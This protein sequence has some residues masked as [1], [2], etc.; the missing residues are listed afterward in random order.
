MSD[1]VLSP[2][3]LVQRPLGRRFFALLHAL[4]GACRLRKRNEIRSLRTLMDDVPD[5][6][7]RMDADGTIRL[8]SASAMDLLGV[9]A[10]ACVGKRLADFV[11]A[12]R[13]AALQRA[14]EE[15]LAAMQTVVCLQLRRADG[16]WAWAETR[17]RSVPAA[18]RFPAGFVASCRD[19]SLQKDVEQSLI[20]ARDQALAANTAKSRFL[21]GMSHELRTPLNA[22]LGF[23]EVM[24]REM[25]GPHGVAKYREY[26]QLIHESG[27]H[28][29]ELINGVLDIS[30]I[31]AGKLEIREEA[32]ALD[33]AV[34]ASVRFVKMV[35]ERE[36][37]TVASVI[38]PAAQTIYADKRAV[39]QILINLL[40]NAVKFT[41]KG[42][43]VRIVAWR[44]DLGIEIAVSDTGIGIAPED[45][46]RLGK[47]F[48]QA[49]NF[50]SRGREGTGLGLA[51]V[52]ALVG[53][54][55][56]CVALESTPGVG[57]TVRVRLPHAFAGGGDKKTATILPLR[58]VA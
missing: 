20:E 25:Y 11:H 51:L 43:T 24:A 41:P 15:A 13:L 30:K 34:E 31:E 4:A 50:S 47:P 8:A 12:D 18:G 49:A 10:Q 6:L 22:I 23:S 52:K 57:T 42:G 16:S 3:T 37:V 7:L 45:L 28:L 26:S 1:D 2:Q 33:Q 27:E 58:G 48:E 53:L 54:H 38:D 55:K 44:V 36:G 29:L 35:A 9:T 40:S 39:R 17:L 21:A 5:L 46:A 32:F 56:G 14:E 19:L